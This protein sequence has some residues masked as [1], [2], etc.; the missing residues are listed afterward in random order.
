MSCVS[1]SPPGCA[2]SV[3]CPDCYGCDSRCPDFVI[4]KNDTK[5]SFKVS[6]TD[7]F[8]PI[9]LTGLVIEAN[10]WASARLKCNI[11]PLDTAIAFADNIG[12]CQILPNDIIFVERSHSPEQMRIVGFDETCNL[13][14]VERGYNGT[15]PQ[16]WKRGSSLKIFRIISAPALS[17]MLYDDI[18]QVDGSVDCNVLI[19]SLLVYE[20][21]VNDTCVPGCFSF[22]FKVIKMSTEP[23]IVPS[24][25]PQ[26]Y[27]GLGVEWTRRYPACGEFWIKVCDSPTAKNFIPPST[28]G[29]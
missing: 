19:E 17:E 12:F 16:A 4:K 21:N 18:T 28:S 23:V 15:V 9:D 14:L 6:V 24:T 25:F 11:T 26:C 20:W 29:E 3:N 22:E 2:S 10:M 13:V 5:P 7:E 8:G 27:L 1:V